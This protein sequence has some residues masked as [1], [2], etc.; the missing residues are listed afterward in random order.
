M[1]LRMLRRY[2]DQRFIGAPFTSISHGQRT[3]ERPRRCGTGARQPIPASTDTI[4]E[5]PFSGADDRQ[6]RRTF[7][8]RQQDQPLTRA[9]RALPA[10]PK[11]TVFA[12]EFLSLH[13][14]DFEY[15]FL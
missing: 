5:E 3:A 7:E 8:A 1:I 11:N 13:N 4:R 14:K 15:I 6:D 10:L 2:G 9:R 12:Q